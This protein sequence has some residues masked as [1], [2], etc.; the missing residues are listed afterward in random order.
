MTSELLQIAI[1]TALKA[2][3]KVLEIYQ[4]GD[5]R[6]YQKDDLSPVTS[7]D[8]T[9]NQVIM[10][11]L[12]RLTPDIPVVSEES[13]LASLSE[14][15][16]W[17]HYWLLDPIDGTGEFI[18]GSGDFAVNIALVVDGW[19]NLGVIHAPFHQTIHYAQKGKGCFKRDIQGQE[20]L[21]KV[22]GYDGNRTLNIAVSRRQ[23]LTNVTQ[24]LDPQFN[25]HHIAYGS[26]SLKSC[27]IAE[28]IA[29]FYIRTGPTGEWDTGASQIILEEAG[30]TILDSEFKP[31]SYN[32]RESVM[33]PDFI[34]LGNQDIP[35]HKV[36][37]SFRCERHF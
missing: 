36:I 12:T 10:D 16:R 23:A 31:L 4:Q 15:S 26:C 37:K 22:A 24:Y 32:K 1:N 8:L 7:A 33:N 34:A 5:F 30:G 18:A 27:L 28:G 13:E 14:R 9:A 6:Q 29:D 35:W 25:Y 11:E 19:P 21:L 2:G 20:T 3:E 17:Q